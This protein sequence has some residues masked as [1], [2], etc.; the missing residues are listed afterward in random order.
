MGST[1]SKEEFAPEESART[2]SKSLHTISGPTKFKKHIHVSLDEEGKL[3][4]MP[5]QWVDLLE[6]SPEMIA[7][8]ISTEDL[9]ENVKPLEPD[10]RIINT[11]KS[12]SP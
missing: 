10:A 7:Y 3:E 1:N 9:D 5:E 12:F 6:L 11:I 2:K 8:K 4:G